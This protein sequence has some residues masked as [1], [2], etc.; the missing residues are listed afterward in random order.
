LKVR[1]TLS[2]LLLTAG[3]LGYAYSESVQNQRLY[4]IER[5]TLEVLTLLK[6]E[7]ANQDK[8]CNTPARFNY[9]NAAQKRL[10]KHMAK[11]EAKELAEIIYSASTS[12]NV[13]PKW[14]E[15][16]GEHE[17]I[18]WGA[19]LSKTLD[20]G[21][22]QINYKTFH[23]LKKEPSLKRFNAQTPEDLYNN[24]ACAYYAAFYLNKML[25]MFG[26]YDKAVKAYNVGPS[27]APEEKAI[28]YF[29]KVERIHACY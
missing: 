23:M 17:S 18:K 22:W 6:S 19:K 24:K 8:P 26:T 3:V 16:I 7:K 9:V 5:V 1:E 21:F 4:Q 11:P 25:K 12:Y 27:L 29:S 13:D 2:Y 14:L 15:A 20:Y 28:I 10:Q